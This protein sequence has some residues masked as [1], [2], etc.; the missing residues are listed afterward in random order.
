MCCFT[1]VVHGIECVSSRLEA[2]RSNMKHL[3][4]RLAALDRGPGSSQAVLNTLGSSPAKCVAAAELSLSN[5]LIPECTD[6]TTYDAIYCDA[7]LSEEDLP[8]FLSLLKP[9]GRMVVVIEE[10][11]LLITRSRDP[12]DFEREVITHVSAAAAGA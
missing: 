4:D 5:V 3:R 9:N 1:G 8:T 7:S 2:A 11:A 12:H 10:E 6:G